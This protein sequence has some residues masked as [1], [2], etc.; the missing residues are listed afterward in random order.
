MNWVNVIHTHLKLVNVVC[1]TIECQHADTHMDMD[2]KYPKSGA[3]C[4][5]MPWGGCFHALV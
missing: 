3:Y 1:V 5:L 2:G 4:N